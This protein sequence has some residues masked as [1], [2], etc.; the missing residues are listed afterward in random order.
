MADDM[1]LLSKVQRIPAPSDPLNGCILPANRT[2]AEEAEKV[3]V[4][5]LRKKRTSITLFPGNNP[6]K[7]RLYT[8]VPL[9]DAH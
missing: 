7:Q 4:L 1:P 9:M 6:I 8:D 5:I 2:N 3:R